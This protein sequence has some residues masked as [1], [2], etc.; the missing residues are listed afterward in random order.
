MALNDVTILKVN[1][2][3]REAANT[4]RASCLICGG[5]AAEYGVDGSTG[6]NTL[7]GPLYSAADAEAIGIDAQ[8]DTVNE[9]LVYHHIKEYFRAF[10]ENITKRPAKPLYLYM[11]S[12]TT[13]LSV[14]VD[15]EEENSAYAAAK[16]AGLTIKRFGVVLNPADGYT[17]DTDD[18]GF[19]ADVALAVA[20]AQATA[21]ALYDEHGPVRFFIECRDFSPAIAGDALDLATLDAESVS[22]V[23]LQDLDVCDKLELHEGYAAIGTILGLKTAKPTVADSFAEV[24]LAYQG[25]IQD[26][27]LGVFLRYGMGNQPLTNWSIVAQ[28]VFYDKR[29]IAPRIFTGT[30]GVF[31][32]NSFTCAA[33]TSDFIFDEL[34]DVHNKAHRAIYGAYVPYIN[35]KVKL[36]DDGTLPGNVVK[37]L[38]AVGNEVFRSMANRDEI[39]NGKTYIDPAQ[40]IVTS[41]KLL[42]KWKM[43]PVGKLENIE[44]ELS[45]TVNLQ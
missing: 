39:S 32:N 9:V 11:V 27:A 5:V 17:P 20:K 30:A 3:V 29:Y 36:K 22:L 15:V 40:Q 42:V 24:G 25:N 37:D 26:K 18:N 21:D 38:E 23:V 1:G 34:D 14:M 16:E 44:G 33:A 7:H 43:V 10:G 41:R 31:V 12:Q 35:T 45:F 4:D 2:L 8:Y 28:G 6:L 19:D 13:P